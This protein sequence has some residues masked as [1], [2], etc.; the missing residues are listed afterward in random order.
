[1]N[2]SAA[3]V[4][5]DRYPLS[6]RIAAGGMGEVWVATDTVLGSTVAVTLLNPAPSQESGF[7]ERFRA[8]TRCSAALH[9]PNI[10]TGF[11]DGEEGGCAYLVMELVVGQPRSQPASECAP[12]PSSPTPNQVSATAGTGTTTGTALSEDSSMPAQPSMTKGR[13]R[14]HDQNKDGKQ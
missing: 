4:L 1:M 14:A 12:A 9:H 5:N 3:T 7:L 8:E 11:D 13:A 2:P 10:T 6:E